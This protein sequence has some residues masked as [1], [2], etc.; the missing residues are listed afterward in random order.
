MGTKWQAMNRVAFIQ[1]VRDRLCPRLRPGDI[2]L[3]DNLQAHK[4]PE[5]RR[6]IQ[7]RGPRVKL[8]PAYSHDF[9]PI[10]PVWSL[11]K[12]R[13]RDNAPRDKA[14][15][16]RTAR[17]A[18]KWVPGLVIVVPTITQCVVYAVLRMNRTDYLQG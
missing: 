1:W 15:L 6:L 12:K 14:A 9:N 3:L 8:L 5:V 2:V 13:L 16:P 4:A 7:P 17:A 18:R 11:V 10:E